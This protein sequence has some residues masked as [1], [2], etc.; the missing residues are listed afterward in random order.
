[1]PSL[2]RVDI[3]GHLGRDAE[4][5]HTPGG[6]A[7]AQFSVATSEKW[8]D[9]ASGEKH[10]KT[11]WHNVVAWRKLAEICS[12]YGTKGRLVY[13]EGKLQTRSWEQDGVKRYMTEILA[14]QVLFLD[15]GNNSGRTPAKN[16]QISPRQGRPEPDDD[17][18]F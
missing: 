4:L 6:Q 2:N 15:K 5:R 17:I 13:V 7:V 16:D 8:T 11:E 9:K 10:E 1:M 3:I 12:E 14:N 18:P